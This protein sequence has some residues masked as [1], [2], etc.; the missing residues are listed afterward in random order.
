[1][2]GYVVIV[3][4]EVT[5]DAVFAEFFEQV[6][7]TVAAYGGK[8]LIRGGPTEVMEGD[9]TPHVVVVVEFDNVEKARTWLNSPEY[10][11]IKQLRLR[12]ANTSVLV[13]EGAARLL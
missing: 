6:P 2:P 8:Y 12:S 4:S 9:W 11:E 5:D 7:A 10:T 13:F 3:D 1:M